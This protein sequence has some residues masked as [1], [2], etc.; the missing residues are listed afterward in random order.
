[1][2]MAGI[3]SDAENRLSRRQIAWLVANEIPDGA[4]VNLGIGI[5]TLCADHMPSQKEI[6]L[7]SENG[8]L[9]FGP[10]PWSKSKNTILTM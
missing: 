2:A 1:M 10:R 6:L 5:P 3:V 8:V 4:Y 7:H 9:G